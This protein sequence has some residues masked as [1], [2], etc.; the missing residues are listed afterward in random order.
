MNNNK[1]KYYKKK[2]L[3]EKNRINDLIEQM[4]R[5]GVLN[6]SEIASELSYYDNHPA[7]LGTEIFDIEKGRALKANEVSMLRKVESAL[8]SVNNGKYGV[9]KMC[10]REIN[11]ERL[12]FIPYAEYCSE[13]QKNLN[14]IKPREE[15]D[16][17]VE[18]EVLGKPF[19][20]GYNDFKDEIGFDA[21]DS[22][23][24]VE[25]FNRMN[26]IDEFYDGDDDWVEPIENVSN[27]QYKN[28]L[29][30]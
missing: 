7:D 17:P 14:S 4:K 12:D 1:L 5:N 29:P 6:N 25:K 10:G 16:R 24:A 9:C 27:E 8:D 2:L 21:E 3:N 11:E 28:Q 23:Q 22:Y 15:N 20:Y 26:Y 30:D 13:C 19:G 18:E